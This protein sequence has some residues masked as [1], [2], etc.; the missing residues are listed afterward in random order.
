MF[1]CMDALNFLDI[2]EV[3]F[4]GQQFEHFGFQLPLVL[5]TAIM[6][7]DILF[8]D[9]EAVFSAISKYNSLLHKLSLS[10]VKLIYIIVAF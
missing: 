1:V 10:E 9:S 7:K 4:E 3:M 8:K 6:K 2:F 5:R